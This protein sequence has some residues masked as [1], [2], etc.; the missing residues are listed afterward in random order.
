MAWSCIPIAPGLARAQLQTSHLAN[1]ADQGW[2][3]DFLHDLNISIHP[4][5][6]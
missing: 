5:I 1:H 6:S 4:W 2:E 3:M